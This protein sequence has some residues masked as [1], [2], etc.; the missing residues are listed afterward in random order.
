MGMRS[1][2]PLFRFFSDSIVLRGVYIGATEI[3]VI[4]WKSIFWETCIGSE[5]SRTKQICYL[6]IV[7]SVCLD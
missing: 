3:G 7:I 6:V 5:Y 1:F 2:Q 4:T